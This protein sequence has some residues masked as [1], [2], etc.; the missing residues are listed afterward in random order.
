[1]HA[2]RPA[3]L[4]EAQLAAV[5]WGHPG[6]GGGPDAA[7]L[8]VAGAGTG[9][10]ATLAHRVAHLVEH[11][12]DPQRILLL[13]F[14]R[15]AAHEMA[16]RAAGLLGTGGDSRHWLPWSGT[17]HAIAARLLRQHA[18][19]LGLPERFAVL[20]R[21]DSADSL[22]SLREDLG[23]ARGRSR[24]PRK[25]T[26]L[27]IYSRC[28]NTGEPLTP[29][30]A[31]EFPWCATHEAA[32]AG[33]F[34]EYARRKQADGVLDYD[35][36][37]LWWDAALEAPVVSESLR[38]AFDHVLVD[39]YQDT[40]RV[41]ASILKRLRPD[42]RGL[43]VVGDDAQSIYR[44][45]GADVHN[46]LDFERHFAPQARRITLTIN[47]RSRQPVL[48]TA[49]ALMAEAA[50][51]LPKSLRAARGHS[52]ARPA[53]VRVLDEREQA[54]FVCDRLLHH[55]ETGIALR[56]QAVLFRSAQHSELLEVELTRRQIPFV[57]HGG[58]RFLEAAHI[59]DLLALLRWTSHPRHRLAGFRTLQCLPGVGPAIA[60]R[61]LE[62]I[63]GAD[64]PFRELA[65]RCAD[66]VP[67]AA[68]EGWPGFVSTLQALAAEPR[69]PHDVDLAIACLGPLL[70]HRHTNLATRL[71]DLHA[72]ARLADRFANRAAF[73]TELALDPPQASGDLAGAPHRDEDYV[74]LSTVHSAK[75]REWHS[76][77]VLN[78]ADGNFPN[79]Y[80]T[81]SLAGLDEERRLMYVA[82]TRARDALYLIEPQRHYVTAQPRLGSLHVTGARSRFLT[83]AVLATL[84]E[85]AAPAAT[86]PAPE[87]TVIEAAVATPLAD[88]GHAPIDGAMPDIARR[89][90]ER[91]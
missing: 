24:F 14:S 88:D 17:F 67:P 4:N 26:C 90:I 46:L 15:R 70:A 71:A 31:G 12:V 10:T 60:K 38:R 2:D 21:A 55:R 37:L 54:D 51:T 13:T 77:F 91:W 57:K 79:E 20:D 65:R 75:G 35:D 78:V 62:S 85:H 34:R 82:M 27:A 89:L 29:V 19:A 30:L 52:G 16:Q 64:E 9:K 47:Y 11:G 8:V 7:L 44:F 49:N 1:M 69:W 43:F 5:R 66:E 61:W 48:D 59:K 50:N 32:L 36:L 83:P 41:Q 73:L 42:G 33:L 23:L 87:G 25:D 84:D 76:V 56:Q 28:V 63:D 3:T 81:G 58:L 72:I 53:L 86:G 6:S 45:R 18:R 80:A 40:N 74:E 22:D 39:E 68:R